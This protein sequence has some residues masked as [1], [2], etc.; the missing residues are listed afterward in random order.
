MVLGTMLRAGYHAECCSNSAKMGKT[1]N[2]PLG[3]KYVDCLQCPASAGGSLEDVGLLAFPR[4]RVA[5]P[6]G[7]RGLLPAP[8]PPRGALC[9]PPHEPS[10]VWFVQS[11]GECPSLAP[12][13]FSVSQ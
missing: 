6:A 3:C 9:S 7:R 2:F 1:N 5:V 4:S 10:A 11:H 12:G 13:C 8:V